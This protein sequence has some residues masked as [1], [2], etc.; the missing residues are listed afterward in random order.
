[1][2]RVPGPRALDAS[3]ASTLA[4]VRANEQDDQRGVS[5]FAVSIGVSVESRGV[6]GEDLGWVNGRF[7]SSRATLEGAR[8]VSVGVQALVLATLMELATS[9][10]L[11]PGARVG[12]A[13]ALSTT[14]EGIVFAGPVYL[15]RAE[16]VGLSARVAHCEASLSDEDGRVHAR[17][18]GTYFV[19]RSSD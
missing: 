6:D 11:S 9:E 16:V 12:A 17:A 14:P 13:T 15:V 10:A 19:V 1:M 7:D 3:T 2:G 18:A 5:A 4:G 8:A